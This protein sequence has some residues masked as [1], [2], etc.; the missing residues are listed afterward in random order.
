MVIIVGNPGQPEPSPDLMIRLAGAPP[1]YATDMIL[2]SK[3]LM[4]SLIF[5]LGGANSVPHR[6]SLEPQHRAF[7]PTADCS[8]NLDIHPERLGRVAP[9]VLVNSKISRLHS[10]PSSHES[11]VEQTYLESLAFLRIR[12][13][14]S[15]GRVVGVVANP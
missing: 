7:E 15:D 3:K 4:V 1:S 13:I 8:Q 2:L 12:P 14:S 9:Q 10:R 6:A 11:G 5:S